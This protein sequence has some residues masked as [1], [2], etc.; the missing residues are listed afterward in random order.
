MRLPTLLLAALLLSACDTTTDGVFREETVVTAVLSAGQA[1]PPITLTRTLP[2]GAFWQP[3]PVDGA[4]VTVSLLDAAGQPEATYPYVQGEDVEYVPVDTPA[5]IGGRR[6]RLEVVVPGQSETITAETVVPTGFSVVEAPPDSV[7]YQDGQGPAIRLS[8][9]VFP[10]RQTVYVF[11]VR[12]LDPLEHE[13]VPDGS[14]PETDDSLWVPIPG[15]GFPP[16]P[17]IAELIYE[18]DI[19]PES[20]WTGNSPLLNAG[21]YEPNPDGTI[22]IRLPWASVTFFGPTELTITA[23]DDALLRFLESQAIQTVP[24]TISPGEIPNVDT[25]VQN[26]HG[27]FGS[28][29]QQET[30]LFVRPAP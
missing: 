28:V 20:F 7:T 17:F 23:V 18:R 19:D 21:N 29:A 2:F 14:T 6:Y 3:I 15:T 8:P 26:G 12:A 13:R 9:S 27:V 10:G 11:T 30:R 25:N 4:T 16:T 22:T 1:L 24:T 5:V